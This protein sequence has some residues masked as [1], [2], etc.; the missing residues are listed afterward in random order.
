MFFP[1]RDLKKASSLSVTNQYHLIVIND[2]VKGLA[3]NYFKAMLLKNMQ[4]LS[5][6][7]NKKTI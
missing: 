3:Q 2:T 1:L 4:D 6:K 5:Q 7:Q